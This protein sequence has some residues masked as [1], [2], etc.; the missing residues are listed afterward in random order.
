MTIRRLNETSRSETGISVK[1]SKYCVLES[2]NIGPKRHKQR[3]E[4]DIS[5]LDIDQSSWRLRVLTKVL[6][7]R[8]CS[9]I[10]LRSQGLKWRLHGSRVHLNRG[11]EEITTIFCKFTNTYAK[12]VREEHMPVKRC[13]RAYLV[14]YL[15]LDHDNHCCFV[16]TSWASGYQLS[17]RPL[18]T[19]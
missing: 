7:I 14:N 5:L 15:R 6:K 13:P 10:H 4:I 17:S 18:V 3:F 16:S 11:F 1:T 19:R 2:E 12:H 9:S 8:T